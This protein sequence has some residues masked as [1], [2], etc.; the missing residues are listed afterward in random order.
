MENIA[1]VNRVFTGDG[2]IAEKPQND[3]QKN[4]DHRLLLLRRQALLF[5]L[6]RLCRRSRLCNVRVLR[7]LLRFGGLV[8][9]AIANGILHHLGGPLRLPNG[10]QEDHQSREHNGGDNGKIGGVAHKGVAHGGRGEHHAQH[11]D[12]NAAGRA[13]KV[14]DGVG[15]T[16]QGLYGDIRHQRH[17]RGAEGSHT[18]QNHQQQN[19][20]EHQ[21]G[22]AL[23]RYLPGVGLPGG[24]NIIGIVG[25]GVGLVAV[26]DLAADGGE[27]R[28]RELIRQGKP[29]AVG[30]Q[31]SLVLLLFIDGHQGSGVVDGRYTFNII[32]LGHIHK[33]QC[34]QGH[35]GNEG[36]HYNEGSAAPFFAVAAVGNGAKQRQQKQS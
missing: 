24:N 12:Q 27:L 22:R 11:Q 3:G 4:E 29:H 23:R 13:H 32:E 10:E 16:S 19:D 34:H 33:A 18:H 14:D 17:R 25:V 7:Q 5:R 28:L 31:E 2:V 36:A 30:G 20:E 9:Q 26:L 6:C 21:R 35:G 1:G 8:L 15:F